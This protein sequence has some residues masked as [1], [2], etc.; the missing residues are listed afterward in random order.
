MFKETVPKLN[1]YLIENNFE[2]SEKVEIKKYIRTLK[3]RNYAKISRKRKLKRLAEIKTY[4]KLKTENLILR[5]MLKKK[6]NM[7][8]KEIDAAISIN[9]LE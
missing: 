6:N 7:L 1:R 5:E 2:K 4:D 8:D 9:S 3:N